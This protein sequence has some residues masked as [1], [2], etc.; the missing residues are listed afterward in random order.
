MREGQ[1]NGAGWKVAG[2]MFTLLQV[3]ALFF[4]QQIYSKLDRLETSHIELSLRVAKLE[5]QISPYRSVIPQNN[6]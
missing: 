4:L 1:H 2:A 5:F 3:V 6:P